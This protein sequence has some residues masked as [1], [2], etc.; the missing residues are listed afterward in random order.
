MSTTPSAITISNIRLVLRKNFCHSAS[1]KVSGSIRQSSRRALASVRRG[2]PA[3]EAS[4]PAGRDDQ[5][6]SCSRATCVHA[7]EDFGVPMLDHI[8][9]KCLL[10]IKQNPPLAPPEA[11]IGASTSRRSNDVTGDLGQR[12]PL[13]STNK[14]LARNAM[15]MSESIRGASATL[16]FHFDC[17]STDCASRPRAHSLGTNVSTLQG[18]RGWVCVVQFYWQASLCRH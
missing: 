13:P 17:L 2:I 16:P 5:K 1:N 8:A 18:V 6:S 7:N 10:T 4:C 3:T 15:G 12:Q 9:G 11:P 14:S